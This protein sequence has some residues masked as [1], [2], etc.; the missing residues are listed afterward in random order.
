MND[1]SSTVVGRYVLYAP[2]ARGG[3][4]TIHLARLLGAEGFS[5]VVAAKRLHRELTEDAELVEMLL[6]EARIASKIH[7]PNVVPVLDVVRSGGEV[8]L[9]QEYVHGVGL[10]RLLRAAGA[11]ERLPGPVVIAIA[12]DMLAGLS[13]AHEARDELG[14]H[15]G[16]VHRDVSPQNVMVGVDGIA[17]LLDFGVAKAALNAHV[18]RVGMFKGKIAYSAPEQLRGE[19]SVATDVYAAGVVIWEALAGRR[20]HPGLRDAELVAAVSRGEVERLTDA[21]SWEAATPDL[22]DLLERVEGVLAKAMAKRPQD[23]WA[24]AASMREALLAAASPANP[25]EVSRWVKTLGR[26]ILEGR[27]RIIVTEESS[28]RQ[29]GS[30]VP[31]DDPSARALARAGAA[32]TLRPSVLPT[33]PAPPPEP[34]RQGNALVGVLAMIGLLLAGILVILLRRLPANEAPSAAVATLSAPASALP[35][36]TISAATARDEPPAPPPSATASAAAEPSASASAAPLPSAAPPRPRASAARDCTPTFA[37][38]GKR[39]TRIGCP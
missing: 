19:V 27:E 13:G 38:D 24:S 33:L 29:R 35:S 12:A 34:A 22:W 30:S 32:P 39:I 1:R 11:A 8:I 2:I 37:F 6:D 16:I 9:V 4:A 23:R 31:A 10:D 5:R 28:W 15:L 21:V 36:A 14:Q 25:G 18:T 20:A 26:E 3:M 17:R 7:H